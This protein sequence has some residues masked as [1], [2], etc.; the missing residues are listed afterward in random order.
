MVFD[1]LT[2]RFSRR[3]R[4]LSEVSRISLED[5]V[6][7]LFAKGGNL[8]A[9]E[10][11]SRIVTIKDGIVNSRK[12]FKKQ[13]SLYAADAQ[14]VYPS[15]LFGYEVYLSTG[16]GVGYSIVGVRDGKPIWQFKTNE[17]I[18]DF[19][20]HKEEVFVVANRTHFLTLKAGNINLDFRLSKP[21]EEMVFFKGGLY[22]ISGTFGRY[23]QP[24]SRD[25][26]DISVIIGNVVIP[27][28]SFEGLITNLITD[29]KYLYVRETPDGSKVFVTDENRII[30]THDFGSKIGS[31]AV[32]TKH[33]Y[34]AVG[35]EIITLKLK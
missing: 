5:E 32:D 24:P 3:T 17:P 12:D 23:G 7:S 26:H 19:V 10:G 31:I 16:E 33:L 27:K 6:F 11:L 4:E 34:A 9:R 21:V 1:F 20:V 14:G 25:K 30:T 22:A 13:I 28:I 18:Y 35:N 15:N 2:S 8:Y 29:G